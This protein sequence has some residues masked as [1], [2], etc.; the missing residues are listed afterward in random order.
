M[1]TAKFRKVGR[2]IKAVIL[3]IPRPVL[4]IEDQQSISTMAAAM[5]RA[6]WGCEVVVAASLQEAKQALDARS[7]EFV[8]AVCDL[9]L[10]DA[11][12]GEVIDLVAQYGVP[13]IAVTGSFGEQLRDM[14]VKKGVV[15]YV[16]KDSINAYDYII[17]LVGRLHKN[18]AIKV[19]ITD[20]SPSLRALLKYMLDAQRLNVYCAEDGQQALDILDSIRTSSWCWWITTCPELT[21][22]LSFWKRARKQAKSIWLSLACQ[23]KATATF[24]RSF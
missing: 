23:Q 5:L 22:S 24:L 9:H 11:P 19:L 13:A 12:H 7:T 6:A 1:E 10:P 4:L 18:A 3:Q 8:A 14:V 21:D 2:G 17:Q 20:D 16:L 15:D